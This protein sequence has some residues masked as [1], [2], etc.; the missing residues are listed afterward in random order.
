MRCRS[1]P[2]PSAA[3]VKTGLLLLLRA[4]AAY[5]EQKPSVSDSLKP[6]ILKSGA[7]SSFISLL[8]SSWN[9][10]GCTFRYDARRAVR[11]IRRRSTRA[12]GTL[13]YTTILIDAHDLV[14]VHSAIDR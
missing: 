8:L 14:C 12:Q 6:T 7:T 13:V 3:P 10:H 4:L 11:Q 2:R 9:G 5:K 1:G